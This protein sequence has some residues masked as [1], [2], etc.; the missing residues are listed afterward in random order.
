MSTNT[1]SGARLVFFHDNK[2]LAYAQSVSG[3]EDFMYEPIEVLDNIFV[4][5]HT[6][7][8]YRANLSAAIFRTVA[9][10]A[11]TTKTPGSLREL[12]IM[13]RTENLLREEGKPAYLQDRI[14][15]KLTAMWENVK[16]SGNSWTAAARGV[17]VQQARFVTTRQRDEF[18]IGGRT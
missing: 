8:G 6:P 18:E 11:S 3:E 14:T 17:V 12:G 9:P 2:P 15:N 7:L 13:P 16:C 1:I 5:E 10:G 4:S